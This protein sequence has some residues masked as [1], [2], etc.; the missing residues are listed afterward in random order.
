MEISSVFSPQYT[1]LLPLLD[2]RSTRLVLAAEALA[3]GR[4][5]KTFVSKASGVSR[6]T[7]NIGISELNKSLSKPVNG[8]STRIRKAGGYIMKA[9]VVGTVSVLDMPS[10]N[11]NKEINL[12]EY[13]NNVYEDFSLE[14]Y[15]PHPHIKAA[16]AS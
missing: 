4:G 5:G 2:E 16:V 9:G 8:P 14:N 1:K 10:I 11:I 12:F 6:S 3:I 13:I 7:I 15:Q